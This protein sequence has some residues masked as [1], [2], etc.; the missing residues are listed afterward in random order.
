MLAGMAALPDDGWRA[1]SDGHGERPFAG[2][3]N[4]VDNAV[5]HGFTHFDLD[6][7]VE[8]LTLSGDVPDADLPGIWHPIAEIDSVGLPTLFAK[9]ARAVLAARNTSA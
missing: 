3:W 6:L 9:A 5:R 4:R 8:W 2:G 7:S 1:S